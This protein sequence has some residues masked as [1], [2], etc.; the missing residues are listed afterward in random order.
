MDIP[1]TREQT[2]SL[3]DWLD[4]LQNLHYQAIDMGLERVKTVFDRLNISVIAR[5]IIVV[6]GT[7]GKGSTSAF[8]ESILIEHGQ[9]VA[10]YSSPHLLK[11]N[12]R[13]RINRSDASDQ[14]LCQ[15]FER[16]ERIRGDISL[17]YFE[18]ATL[19]AM[20]LFQSYSL[21]VAIFEVGLGG[22]LD[23]VNIL[24]SDASI[25]TNIALDH[26][27]WLGNDRN[28]IAREKAGVMRSSCPVIVGDGSPPASLCDYAQT[29]KAQLI[30]IQDDF[31]I[32]VD[33]HH[34]QLSYLDETFQFQFPRLVGFHQL[35]NAACAIV[36]LLT[37]GLIPLK[38]S[39]SKIN[40]ALQSVSLPGRLQIISS[41]PET[42]VD[43]GHNPDAAS[44]LVQYVKSKKNTRT[45]RLV[46]AMMADKD[47]E[48]VVREMGEVCR[49]WY[50]SNLP[51]ER[52]AT[53]S[54]LSKTIRNTTQYVQIEEFMTPSLAIQRAQQ[55]AHESDLILVFGSF[56]TAADVLQSI[57]Y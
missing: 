35:G 19:A 3:S 6:A 50:C 24:D 5:K 4:Y 40:N 48:G 22:R 31:S 15:A 56:S 33:A 1:E 28:N 21:D 44:K 41:T 29:V 30:R 46:F 34:W 26:Q 17:S 11:F 45:I 23:A 36:C 49:H 57:S 52:A 20:I 37:I 43:V 14:A 55:D 7:N 18:F 32:V 2:K 39:L 47:I 12:E 10:V 9:S 16:I 38:V 42:L 51:L 27:A 13:F 53:A 25:I 54:F 8:L